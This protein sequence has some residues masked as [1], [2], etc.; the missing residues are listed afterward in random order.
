MV[1][2]RD[3]AERILAS[4]TRLPAITV[5]GPRQSGKTTLCRA[6][7]PE[8]AYVSL[9]DPGQRAFAAEDPRRFLMGLG[10]AA[11]IDEVQN[12][13]SLAS[14][15]QTV[16]DD[17]PAPGR[18]I[19]TGS[20]AF[21]LLPRVS[22]SLAGRTGVFHLLPLSRTETQRFP[23]WPATLEEALF[24]GGYPRVFDWQLDAGEWYGA[25][26]AT[27]LERD[28]RQLGNV[29]DLA[30]FQRFAQLAAGRTGQELNQRDFARDVGVSP[31]TLARWISV[32]EASYLVFK[33]PPFHSNV[34]KRLVKRPKLYFHDTGLACWL[35][36]IQEPAQLRTHPLRG[37]LFETWVV[38]E[39]VKHRANRMP[40]LARNLYFYREHN[41][42][43]VDLLIERAGDVALL[44]AKSAVTPSPRL[45][46]SGRRVRRHLDQAGIASQLAV[47]YAGDE[48]HALAAGEL[49]PW[50]DLDAATQ[51]LA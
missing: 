7:F 38:S 40:G 10:D 30:A 19:L 43:E 26:V 21:N 8:H 49:I 11:V 29:G 13:P 44:E 5:T 16:I 48:A 28:V 45:L 24:T 18:W 17:S 31:P 41:L 36:G 4:A 3:I 35:L 33:L 23:S 32:L 20:Q 34:G 47:V 6:L 15:L 51:R 42:G 22:Q 39:T 2:T 14:A 50:D 25:Y 12:V 46:D 37:A 27:Y 1:V 9:E